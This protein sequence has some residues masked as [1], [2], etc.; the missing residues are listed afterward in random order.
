MIRLLGIE[1]IYRY[2][3]SVEGLA[4]DWLGDNLY[5]T[6][7]E[8]IFVSRTDGRFRKKF[9]YHSYENTDIALDPERG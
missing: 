8:S 9:E 7:E 3:P 1:T 2:L 6:G 4:I 5:W